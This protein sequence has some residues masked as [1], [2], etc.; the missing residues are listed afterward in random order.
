MNG[1]TLHERLA[2]A[3]VLQELGQNPALW[4]YETAEAERTDAN[5]EHYSRQVADAAEL[6]SLRRASLRMFDLSQSGRPAEEVI[7]EAEQLLFDA[8]RRENTAGPL[9]AAELVELSLARIAARGRGTPEGVPTGYADIDDCLG[10]L[11][12]GQLTVLGARPS[13]GKTALSVGIGLNASSAGNGV[14]FFSLEMSADEVMD[15]VF[16]SVSGVPLRAIQAGNLTRQQEADLADAG[17]GFAREKFFIDDVSS[18]TAAQVASVA[19]R[20]VA[21]NDV[22]LV[23]VDYLQLM[24]PE[25]PRENRALQVGQMARSL[26]V[27]ARLLKVPVLLLSQLNR[28][29]EA[30]PGRRPKLSDLRDSGEIEQHADNVIL[31]HR[32][33]AQDDASPR[34]SIEALILKVRN[35]ATGDVSLSYNRRLTRFEN[36]MIGN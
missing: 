24:T 25:N 32:P 9:G 26:K 2:A 3:G 19:R 17:R 8:T 33:P 15:R 16:A 35:G 31:L 28:E 22:R 34:W 12:P 23:V 36:A 30:G 21:R 1:V 5:A 18:R 13:V 14:L 7:P 6:R 20:H 10:G 27:T 4:L 11:K 29:S